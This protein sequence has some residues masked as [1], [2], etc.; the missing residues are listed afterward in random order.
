MGYDTLQSPVGIF[1]WNTFETLRLSH[2]TSVV[3]YLW[4]GWT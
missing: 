2:E 3:A 4:E 1:W